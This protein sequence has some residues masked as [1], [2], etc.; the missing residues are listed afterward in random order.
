MLEIIVLTNWFLKDINT[1][2]SK[3][4][5]LRLLEPIIS[6][7]RIRCEALLKFFTHSKQLLTK[8]NLENGKIVEGLEESLLISGLVPSEYNQVIKTLQKALV[9][10]IP[11]FY[12]FRVDNEMHK[13]IENLHPGQNDS[14]SLNHDI[15]LSSITLQSCRF[16]NR[17]KIDSLLFQNI[18]TKELKVC[19]K[20]DAISQIAIELDDCISEFQA[21]PCWLNTYISH[22]FCGGQWTTK[23]TTVEI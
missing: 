12:Q 19:Q 1:F 11:E 13:C 6:S 18:S 23:A 4:Q 15:F 20:C 16:A 9:Q 7:T 5:Y 14:K 2:S 10:M 3:F 8:F 17:S 21:T 22:C